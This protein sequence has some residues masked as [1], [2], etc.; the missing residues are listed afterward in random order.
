MVRSVV[1]LFAFA[2]V[3]AAPAFA[4]E[5][6][7][8]APF[9][10]IELEAGGDVYIV[11]GAVQRVTLLNGSRE[12]TSF[13]IPRGNQL[14]ISTSCNARCPHNYNLRI[15][16]ESPYVPDVAVHA[17]GRIVAQRG[18]APQRQV[19]AAVSAGGTI[20]LRAAEADTVSAAVNAGGDIYVR[21]R[22]TL[23]AAVN[24]GG[25]I[26]YSGNPSVTMAV[27]DGGDVRR[28]Y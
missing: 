1:P 22:S 4:D 7:P 26:H 16:I 27:H 12:F 6:I 9:K 5:P 20:D 13:R 3:A 2:L 15:R 23:S 19:S 17:G 11:P 25:D 8:V 21:P 18:F 28:D 14:E 24:A 10:S